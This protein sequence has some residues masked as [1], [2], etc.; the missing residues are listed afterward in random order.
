MSVNILATLQSLTFRF[1]TLGTNTKSLRSVI[2]LA[3]NKRVVDN[4]PQCQVKYEFLQDPKE[5]PIIIVKYSDGQEQSIKTKNLHLDGI[6]DIIQSTKQ[7]IR[8]EEI[9]KMHSPETT[10][11]EILQPV[12]KKKDTGAKANKK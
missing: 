11:Q 10:L 9:K 12:T 2:P 6:V 3:T 7:A 8:V 5:E 4:A 1:C